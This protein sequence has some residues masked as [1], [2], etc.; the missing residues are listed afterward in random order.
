MNK[1]KFFITKLIGEKRKN[2]IK[3]KLSFIYLKK[4][5]RLKNEK[6]IIYLLVPQHGN[7]GD[8]AIAYATIKF[9]SDKFKDYKIVEFERD[10]IYKYGLAIKNILNKDDV[11]V[12]HGGGN[13][14]NLYIQEEEPRRFIVD[15]FKKNKI[16]SMTQTITFSSDSEGKKE[17]EKTVI[18]YNNNNNL[19]LLA[20]EDKSYEIMSELFTNNTIIKVPDIVF[21]LEDLFKENKDR[22]YVMTCLR[23]D[24][25]SYFKEKSENF[26]EEL[27]KCYG[28][29][30][31]SD[32]TIKENVNKEAR[33]KEL[34]RIWNDFR[35]AKVVITDRLHGMIFATITK[36]P[37]IVLRSLDHKVIESYKWIKDLN[38]IRFVEDLDINNIKILIEELSSLKELDKTTFKEKYFDEL[39]RKIGIKEVR[40]K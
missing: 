31:E 39:T 34:F 15:N 32:T 9:L 1:I 23:K 13:M 4:F 37:C 28:N 36:T 6:K 35:K 25:E 17:K 27:K 11:I 21:Y 19:T 14:G 24:K 20:R 7:L 12:L 18:S 30:V 3:Y 26:L 10:E 16:I 33:E 22:N 29:V 8:Q 38:Y 5:K 40:N 2:K